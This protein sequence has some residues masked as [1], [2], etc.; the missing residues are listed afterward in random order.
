MTFLMLALI[1]KDDP[2]NVAVGVEQI[3]KQ[4]DIVRV[5]SLY[6]LQEQFE[7]FLNDFA[8]KYMIGCDV[9]VFTHRIYKAL[10]GRRNIKVTYRKVQRYKN[11]LRQLALDAASR[12]DDVIAVI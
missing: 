2:K 1:D 10:A 6:V 12:R 3:N 8:D 9:Q 5:F 11:S 7:E 4:G